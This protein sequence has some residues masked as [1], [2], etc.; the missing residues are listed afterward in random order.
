MTHVPAGAAIPSPDEERRAVGA[1]GG[2]GAGEARA[3]DGGAS[4]RVLL[5]SRLRLAPVAAA[6]EAEL[7]ALHADPRA[8]AEDSTAPLTDPAQMRWVLAQ[9][10]E[11]WA[12]HGIG[13]VCVRAR[14]GV[15][16]TGTRPTGA[17]DELPPGLLG[18]VGLSPLTTDAGEELLSAYWR[19]SPAVTGR[20]VATEA[21]SAL[22]ADPHLGPGN[23]E[24]VAITAAGNGPSRAL[25]ARLRF[26]SAPSDGPVPG[27]RAD[28][29]LLVRPGGAPPGR[30]PAP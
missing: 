22:L 8:F 18:V 12:R 15:R 21:M 20:G 9:W 14:E 27:G 24:V 1:S 17:R 10:R 29:V 7:F 19:L 16:P 23:R 28:D 13:Y 25:A 6:D 11:S 3:A 5:T 30:T 2:G 4:A 26:R